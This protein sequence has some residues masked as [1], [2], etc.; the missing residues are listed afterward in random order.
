METGGS[1]T[2]AK[3]DLAFLWQGQTKRKS[4]EDRMLLGLSTFSPCEAIISTHG[5]LEQ[6]I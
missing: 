4:R 5:H 3:K 6:G 1:T 2:S